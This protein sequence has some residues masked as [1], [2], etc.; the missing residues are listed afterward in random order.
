MQ[1]EIDIHWHDIIHLIY[2]RSYV[3]L[4]YGLNL[5]TTVLKTSKHIQK[6][7]KAP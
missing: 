1:I 7:R 2:L 3:Y 5:C 4:V 6:G